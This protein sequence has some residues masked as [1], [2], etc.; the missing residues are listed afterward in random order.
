MADQHHLFLIKQ[1]PLFWNQ[2]RQE[3][4][5]VQ[6]DLSE[7]DLNDADLVGVNL[8]GTDKP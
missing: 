1:G 6:P 4:A 7:A 8:S 5:D 2:W 3:H